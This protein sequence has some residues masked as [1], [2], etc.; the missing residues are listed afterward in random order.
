MYKKGTRAEAAEGVISAPSEGSV[1][2]EVVLE[3]QVAQAV[4]PGVIQRADEV[5]PA[6]RAPSPSPSYR[7]DDESSY[8]SS[9]EE[10]AEHRELLGV[11]RT[12]TVSRLPAV[13]HI[14]RRAEMGDTS[15]AAGMASFYARSP[16]PRER[17][18]HHIEDGTRLVYENNIVDRRVNEGKIS[19]FKK[20]NL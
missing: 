2:E 11:L 13:Q 6:A 19:Y 16:T 10:S 1:P 8:Y 5:T 17:E 7:A 3:P 4:Q 15:S 20:L 12:F 9:E 18:N 14:T